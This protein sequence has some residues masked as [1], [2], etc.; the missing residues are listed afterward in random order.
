MSRRGVLFLVVG[1]SGAG[2]DSLIDG[3]R[4]A[5][6]GDPRFRFP[7]R[8]ITRPADA[9]GEDH[10]A[11]TPA[12]F[13]AALA[14]GAFALNWSAHGLRYGVPRSIE[15]DLAGGIS[16]VANVS[17]SVLA[18][19][20][21]RYDPA[22]AVHVTV[23]PEVLARRLAE[24][25]RESPEEVAARLARAPAEL[26]N[27][28]LVRTLANDGNL[29]SAVRRFVALLLSEAGAAAGEG[30]APFPR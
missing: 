24:R 18:E 4:R 9:G 29:E 19:A 8:A 14:A 20:A 22:R 21:G 2:K 13:E 26:S 11:F 15:P 25:G 23:Q 3:A 7:R 6:W 28:P 10:E 1:P 17:R 12:A 27:G 16:V 30:G 5:L